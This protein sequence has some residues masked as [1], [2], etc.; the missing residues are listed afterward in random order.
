MP[1][2]HFNGPLDIEQIERQPVAKPRK[3][4]RYIDKL[5]IIDNIEI[6]GALCEKCILGR[7]GIGDKLCWGF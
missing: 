3:S 7:D 5:S 2:L 6:L 1:K 4:K